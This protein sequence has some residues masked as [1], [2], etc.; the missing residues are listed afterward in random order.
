MSTPANLF[1]RL[2]GWSLAN[3]VLVLAG[4]LALVVAGVLGLRSLPVDVFPDLDKPTVTLMTEAGGMA[5]EEVEQLVSFPLETAMNGMPGVTRVRSVSGIG[6][7]IVFVEFDW[8]SNI[9][10]NRQSVAERLAAVRERL[11]TGVAPQMGPIASIMGEV[12]LIA[13]PIDPATTNPM[14]V[15]EYA[16]WVLRPRLL[17]VPGVAQVIPI[18]GGVKQ[19][20]VMPDPAQMRALGISLDQLEAAVAGF[21]ANSAGGFLERQGQEWLVRGVGRSRRIEDLAGLPVGS[22]RGVA[23]RLSQVAEVGFAPA[24]ARGSA[25]F[26]GRPAVIVSVQKQPGTDS[27]ALTRAVEGALD[28]VASNLPPGIAKPRFLFRQADFIEAALDNVQ[29]ALRDG[30]ILV[31]IVLFAF[32]MN[33]RSTVIS[34]VAIP[35]SL[36]ASVLVFRAMGLSINTMTLGGLAIAIGELVD[37][38][39]VDVEN[40]LR[41]LKENRQRPAPLPVLSVIARACSEVRSGVVL[42]TLTVVLVFVPLFALPGM[43][44]RLFVPLGLAY[45][46]S[47]LAS[48]AVAVTVTP[49]LCFFL[50]PTMPQ[51]GHGDGALVAR[52]KETQARLLGWALP[53]SGRV[54]LAATALVVAVAA[55][56]PFFPRTFLPPFNEGT[57][58]INVLLQPGVSLAE[59]TRIGQ[60]A[61]TL[62]RGVPE[63]VQV[64]R[65]TGRAELDE[66]AEGVHSSEL[67]VD[68]H[69]EGRPRAEVI[70]DIRSRLARLPAAVSVGQPIAHRLDHLLSGVRAQ[71]AVKVQGDDLDQIRGLAEELRSRFAAIPGIADLQIEKQVRIPQLRVV[72]D[73]PALAAH[74]VAPAEVLGTVARLV[75]GE[76]VG[77]VVD[78]ARRFD[79]VIRLPDGERDPARLAAMPVSVPGG[80]VP[81]GQLARIEEGDGPNQIARD[82]GRRRIVVS[83]NVAG[84]LSD[85]VAQMRRMVADTPLPQGVSVRIE[86]QFQAQEDAQARIAWLASL[87]LALVFLVLYGRYRSVRLVAMVM[88]GIPAALVG[89][90]LALWLSGQPLSVAALVGFVTLTGIATRNGILK[91]SHYLH[92]HDEEGEPF[93]DGL[94]LRGARERL[95][96]VLMTALTAALALVPLLL[97]ADAPGK[98]ILHPVAVVIFGGLVSS[99]LLDTLLTPLL[100]RRYG[101]PALIAHPGAADAAS[102]LNPD[103]GV[104]P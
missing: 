7:S 2:V 1:D 10:R 65:R 81:L 5:P 94:I 75:G 87:S 101:A 71:I 30:A 21:A 95:T 102:S 103:K 26:D 51:L 4:A 47:I 90:V 80:S 104:T 60:L 88:V 79:L 45:I 12:L 69:A 86:G 16:D 55:S 9:W 52:L 35:L 64:G 41:R 33:T 43:E 39:V 91:V 8:G 73:Y 66:H 97:A 83:A 38:A 14:A 29:E 98:E 89:A 24:V 27:I 74:G 67:E 11:P 58:T 62:V 82:N 96:P 20:R 100:F 76:R 93:G 85:A 40:V 49:V 50:L 78:G 84:S 3:R 32:L 23:V 22:P 99:T 48:L 56:V 59:S 17:S 77:E 53:R 57:L 37:D 92:L 36:L 28:E 18:G 15:R 54:L 34:L 72:L 19:W 63:V 25:G 31:A 46:V 68:L 13:L 44:G 42:A 70:A 61:E 6:L